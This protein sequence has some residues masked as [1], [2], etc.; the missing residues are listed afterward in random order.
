[1]PTSASTVRTSA[2]VAAAAII[3][4]A[5]AL[6]HWA[7]DP[8]LRGVVAL[9]PV[10]FYIAFAV[11]TIRHVRQLDGLQQRMALEAM[12][13]AAT[14]T[15]LAALLYGQ[16]EWAGLVPSLDIRF[17]APTLLLLYAAGRVVSGRRY[18]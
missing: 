3:G 11:I 2:L 7:V 8:T 15:G 10:P 13:F 5:F 18:Q 14:I 12:T 17:V 9:V 4:S 6:K 1:M 16:L